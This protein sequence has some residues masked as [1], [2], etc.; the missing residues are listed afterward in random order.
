M[1][2]RV[3]KNR[4]QFLRLK[5]A[6]SFK[7]NTANIIYIEIQHI[8]KYILKYKIIYKYNTADIIYIEIQQAN[9]IYLEIQHN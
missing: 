1:K 7:Y 5:R 9:I 2:E 3:L 8:I 6:L 4:K